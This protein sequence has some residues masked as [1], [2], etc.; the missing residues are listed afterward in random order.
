MG[1][2]SGVTAH[3]QNLRELVLMAEGGM[4]PA[5]ALVAATRPAAELLG[6]DGELGTIEPGKRADLVV[7][8]AD[9]YELA[10]LPERIRSVYQD[11]RLVVADGRIVRDD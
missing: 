10:A 2:D 3:G 9:P 11:G 6:L 1:T 4:S 7:V 5:A 8:D